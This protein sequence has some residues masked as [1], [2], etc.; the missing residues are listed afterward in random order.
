MNSS[1]LNVSLPHLPA[2]P[3]ENKIKIGTLMI[4]P[5]A[6]STPLFF[7]FFFS[8]TFC[9]DDQNGGLKSRNSSGFFLVM[10]KHS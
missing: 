3:P 7:F 2:P 10:R 1:Y 8:G 9:N 4:S 6:K 5:I